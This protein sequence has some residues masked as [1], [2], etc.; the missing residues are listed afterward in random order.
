MKA[1]NKSYMKSQ[2]KY[3]PSSTDIT[4]WNNGFLDPVIPEGNSENPMYLNFSLCYI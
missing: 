4:T 3:R 1:S 2:I